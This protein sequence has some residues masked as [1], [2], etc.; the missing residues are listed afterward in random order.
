MKMFMSCL[1]G[2]GTWSCCRQNELTSCY[3]YKVIMIC[4][5]VI[6]NAGKDVLIYSSTIAHISSSS[7]NF[8][9]QS[10]INSG[11]CPLPSGIPTSLP[12][13]LYPSQFLTT[14]DYLPVPCQLPSAIFL[15][16]PDFSISSRDEQTRIKHVT[17][18]SGVWNRKTKQCAIYI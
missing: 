12:F 8:R 18:Q 6:I 15:L 16:H 10:S 7:S 4:V 11:P 9:Q 2:V 1:H 14:T 3:K 17:R 5:K 13:P